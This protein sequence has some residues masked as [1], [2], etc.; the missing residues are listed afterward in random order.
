MTMTKGDR[1][2]RSLRNLV[3]FG[4]ARRPIGAVIESSASSLL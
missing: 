4:E 1:E 3:Q 2:E